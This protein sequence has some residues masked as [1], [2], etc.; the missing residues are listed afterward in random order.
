MSGTKLN[1]TPVVLF[2]TFERSGSGTERTQKM[3][4]FERK[5]FFG[6]SSS[7]NFQLQDI[8]KHIAA[9]VKFAIQQLQF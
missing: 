7:K 9:V 2:E 1:D 4:V 6:I 5:R 3:M 8:N